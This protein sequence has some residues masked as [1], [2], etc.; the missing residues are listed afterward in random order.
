MHF[1]RGSGCIYIA[2]LVSNPFHIE[3]IINVK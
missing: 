3:R 2:T 1:E